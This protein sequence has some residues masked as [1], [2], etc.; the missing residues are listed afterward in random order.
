MEKRILELNSQLEIE[1]EELK[2]WMYFH[3]SQY[4]PI[5]IQPYLVCFPQDETQHSNAKRIAGM[6]AEMDVMEQKEQELACKKICKP[7]L[8][9]Y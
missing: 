2:R 8:C 6:K 1:G 4:L 7:L 5:S 3:V 9:L